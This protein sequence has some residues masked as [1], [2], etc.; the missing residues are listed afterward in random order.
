[1]NPFI[2]ELDKRQTCGGFHVGFKESAPL[3]AS[4]DTV[5]K[6]RGVFARTQDLLK[7]YCPS[8]RG[9]ICPPFETTSV[10]L[11]N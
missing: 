11:E 9:N 1:M 4:V 2:F 7:E 5:I 6:I 8:E 3:D 10:E